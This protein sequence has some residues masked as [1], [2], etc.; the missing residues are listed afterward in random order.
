MVGAHSRRRFLAAA[1]AALPLEG[2]ISQQAA[3]VVL[4]ISDGSVLAY[5][6]NASSWILPPGSSVKPFVFEALIRSGKLRADETYFCRGGLRVGVH[7]FA[8]SHPRGLLPMNVARAIAY[9]CNAATVHFAGRFTSNELVAALRG[10]GFRVTSGDPALLALGEEG[11]L[12]TPL[13]LARAYRQ[14]AQHADAAVMEGLEGAVQYGT[15]QAAAVP[16]ASVAGKTGSVLSATGLRAAWFA[17]FAPS[18]SPQVAVVVATQGHSGG[19]DA[20]PIAADLL[21]RYLHQGP[22]YRVRIGSAIVTLGVDEYVA[23]VLA[24]ECSVFRQPEALKAMAVA[25]RTFAAHERGRHAPDG[26]DFCNTTHCQRVEPDDVNAYLI[27][28]AESTAGV[29]IRFEGNPAFTPYTMS[30]GGMTES[31]EALWAD[32]GAPYLPVQHDAYCPATPWTRRLTTADVQHALRAAALNC[33]PRLQRIFVLNRTASGRARQLRLDGEGSVLISAEAFRLAIGRTLGW[34][35]IRSNWFELAG[36]GET[37]I[38]LRGRGEGHGVGLCQKGAEA[39]AAQGRSYREILAFYYPGTSDTNWVRLGGEGVV[40]YATDPVRDRIVLREAEQLRTML[41]WRIE[42]D[43]SVYVY[44]NVDA[45]RSETHEPGWV[46]ARSQGHRIDLQ[47]VLTLQNRGTLR[48]TLRHELLHIAVEDRA[49][50]GLPIWFREGLVEWLAA[51]PA[52]R[53]TASL[54]VKNEAAQWSDVDLRQRED[55]QRAQLGYREAQARVAGLIR[56]YGE[57]TVLGWLTSGLPDAVKNSSASTQ[58]TKSR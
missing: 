9:S 11:I 35:L 39:M 12:I 8:C 41:P 53:A 38:E 28:A 49:H 4:R 36:S 18:R 1:I 47:P 21:R 2:E 55:A 26:F 17:G 29:T 7:D 37:S 32:A 52:D 27:A 34:N 57:T 43:V 42:T 51:T 50:P 10:A 54:P 3:T 19:S 56:S 31:A 58:T 20:A 15:A 30:C 40:V 24:G 48:E 22:A 5:T 44:P 14:L 6:G 45:F 25:A 23:A 46:A 33:P 13:E 16:M